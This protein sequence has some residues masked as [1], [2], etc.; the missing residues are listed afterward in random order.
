MDI[1][2][3][4]NA[5]ILQEKCL[6]KVLR[7]ALAYNNFTDNLWREKRVRHVN[8]ILAKEDKCDTISP[9]TLLNMAFYWGGTE[10]GDRYYR[11]IYDILPNTH[12]KSNMSIRAY[13][14]ER[15]FERLFKIREEDI[16]WQILRHI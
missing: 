6:E 5:Q 4:S 7:I 3:F 8:E 9:K 13:L 12:Y 15:G 16:K 10:Q 14:G 2:Q 1:T 11:R